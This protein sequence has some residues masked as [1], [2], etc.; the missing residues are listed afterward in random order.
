[1]ASD[2]S[3]ARAA[4]LEHQD[5]SI[6]ARKVQLFEDNKVE[7]VVETRRPFSYY[8]L[9][10]PPSPIAPGVKAALWATGVLVVLLFL[11]ALLIGPHQRPKRRHAALTPVRPAAVGL[12][13]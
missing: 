9:Q 2:N 11:A 1:M 4:G 5:Q 12:L 6:K 10:T 8:V 13:A 7:E 3:T